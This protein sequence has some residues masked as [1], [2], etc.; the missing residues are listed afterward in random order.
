MVRRRDAPSRTMRPISRCACLGCLKRKSMPAPLM[1][2]RWSGLPE[3]HAE[4]APMAA[5]DTD[6]RGEILHQNEIAAAHFTP[7]GLQQE[8]LRIRRHLLHRAVVE[9]PLVPAICII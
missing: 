1:R 8:G 2:C 6:W 5:A 4:S 7:V 9:Q 3:A